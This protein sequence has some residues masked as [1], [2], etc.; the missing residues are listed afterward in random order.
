M[1]IY[2]EADWAVKPSSDWTLT[3]IKGGVEVSRYNL[4]DRSTT[5][6]GR[7]LDMVHIPIHHE[8]ASRQ[9]AR[10][11]F[12]SQGIPWLKDLQ[13]TH[14]VT[15]NKHRLPAESI[16]RT[17]SNTHYRGSRGVIIYPR[18]MIQFGA[19]TRFYMLEG[20]PEYERGAIQA[21]LQQKKKQQQ[22]P[23]EPAFES[24]TAETKQLEDDGV[25]LSAWG[26]SMSDDNEIDDNDRDQTRDDIGS[27]NKTLPMDLQVPEKHLKSLQKLNALKYKL[28]NLE[29]EDLRIRRKGELTEGQEKQLQRNAEREETLKKSIANLEETLYDKLY[30]N[31]EEKARQNRQST[32]ST[33]NVDE[34]DD[35]FF[36]RTK[37]GHK[38]ATSAIDTEAESEKTLIA[39]WKK[40]Y[41]EFSQSQR[42]ALPAAEKRV[43]K[44][45]EKLKHSQTNETEDAFFIQNDLQLAKEAIAKVVSSISEIETAMDEN[46]KLLSIVN[47]K[48]R[49]NNET[50]YI[51]EG[52]PP[53][54]ANVPQDDDIIKPVEQQMPTTDMPP[55]LNTKRKLPGPNAAMGGAD[56]MPPPPSKHNIIISVASETRIPDPKRKRVVGPSMPP[57]PSSKPA[58]RTTFPS[59]QTKGTLAFLDAIT[60][61][62]VQ[63]PPSRMPTQSTES[64]AQQKLAPNPRED[65]WQAPTDQDGSGRTTLNEKFGGRY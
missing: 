25:L 24:L 16:G 23:K 63:Q 31:P 14:G 26:I 64:L 43:Y 2:K 12:D 7:A 9:H 49:W 41:Q 47:P 11:S 22:S 29:T 57:P 3:E 18:D 8:S 51:G 20:P 58:S 5:V 19:S 45:Q 1:S 48:I 27:S 21:K 42:I 30:P 50:G 13:S 52:L 61:T 35:D 34:E 55:P 4:H 17:E 6:F 53:P 33:T 36:D 65:V 38:T 32:E 60:M 46:T 39:K 40:L 15:V 44:L 10:I 28:A 54:T 62:I 56:M 59:H 37:I